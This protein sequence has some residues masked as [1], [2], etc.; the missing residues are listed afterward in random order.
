MSDFEHIKLNISY[1][2]FMALSATAST[3]HTC[4]GLSRFERSAKHEHYV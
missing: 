4:R 1:D 3:P 2:E